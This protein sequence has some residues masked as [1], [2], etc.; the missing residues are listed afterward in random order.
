[1]DGSVKLRYFFY[2][3][4]IIGIINQNIVL[5][6]GLIYVQF[7]KFSDY[8]LKKPKYIIKLILNPLFT[9]PIVP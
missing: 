8:N 3:K 9:A 4:F 1:M 6:N 2:F 7:N 5:N